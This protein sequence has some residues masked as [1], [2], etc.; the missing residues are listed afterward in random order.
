MFKVNNKDTR[1]TPGLIFGRKSSNYILFIFAIINF[2]EET[3]FTYFT[4]IKFSELRKKEVENMR[5]QS[6][7]EPR[8]QSFVSIVKNEALVISKDFYLNDS[9]PVAYLTLPTSCISVSCI[10]IKINLNFYFHT[11]CGALKL[12]SALSCVLTHLM[13]LVSF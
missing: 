10:K 11:L 13:A 2:C 1:T 9:W 8:K 12:L 6:Y 4:R 3:Y 7:L 5:I